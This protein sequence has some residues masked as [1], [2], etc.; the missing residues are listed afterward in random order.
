[1]Y[2][3]WTGFSEHDFAN[4]CAK[5]E[6]AMMACDDYVGNVR[7]GDLCFDLVACMNEE[8]TKWFLQYDLYVGGVDTGYGYSNRNPNL[9]EYAYDY[10]EGGA[11]EDGMISMTY[12]DFKVYAEEVFIR[13]IVTW[14]Y[15]EANLV[16]KALEPLNIW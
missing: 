9:P 2:F 11:F 14:P 12:D 5:A 7:V 16:Q 15:K 4:Y 1:M 8:C 13:Y 10:A 6:N 3:D